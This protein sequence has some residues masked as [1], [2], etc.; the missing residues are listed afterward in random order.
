MSSR[1]WLLVPL[2]SGLAIA[3]ASAQDFTVTVRADACRYTQYPLTAHIPVSASAELGATVTRSGTGDV[4]PSQVS[5]EG[6]G[7]DVTWIVED[8]S[9]DD[10]R[11]YVMALHAPTPPGVEAGVT[12]VEQAGGLEIR[13]NGEPFT[14]YCTS[15]EAPKPYFHPII[16]PTGAPVTRSFPMETVEGESKD[17]P[18]H[19]SLWFTHDRVNGHNFWSEG[20]DAGRTVHR[21]YERLESG[22][23]YGRFIALT[24]WVAHDGTKVCED[25]RDVR[26]YNVPS[27]RLFDFDITWTASEG[28]LTLGD[29]KEGV[30]GFR[31]ADSMA[32]TRGQGHIL[33]ANGDRDGATWGKAAPWCDYWGPVDG[34]TVGIA[35]L[36]SPG[37]PGH[38]THWHVRDYGLFCANIFGLSLFEPGSGKDG[39]VNLAQGDS[40]RFRYRV[41]IHEG[42]AE[43]AGVAELY[44][45]YA[46]PPAVI[47]ERGAGK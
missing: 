29:T 10:A 41:F 23:V 15:T 7:V 16:G 6:D 8:L 27:G 34:K 17:H 33:N 4:V 12:L 40:L 36:D 42:D 2:A 45:G 14:R 24:D 28:P 18:H 1:Y 5:A 21:G 43:Q 9:Q 37:N 44:A 35:M 25:R 20:D 38:P 19:R 26:V 46:S 31:V 11:A 32:V 39:T 47:V 3:A 22:P 30:F 13:V